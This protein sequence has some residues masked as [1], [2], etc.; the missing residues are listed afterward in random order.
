MSQFES[1][2]TEWKESW[3]DDLL[4]WVSGFANAEGGRLEIGRNDKGEIVGLADASK[5]LED[6]PNKI[7]DL[8]GILVAV[9][10]HH[11]KGKPWIAIEVDAYPNPI[12]YRGHYYI[13]SGSTLQELKGAALD[14]FLLRKQGRTWDSVPVPKVKA[15]DLSGAAIKQFRKLAER[16]GR[17]DPADLRVSDTA[18]IDKLKLT[19]GTYLKRAALLLFHS[20]PEHFVTG[21]FVKIGYFHTA[22]EFAYH[23]EV[24][25]NLF[26]QSAKTIDLVRTK[27]LKAAIT[28]EGIHRIERYPVPD[29]ALREAILNALVHRDYA[30]GAPVQIRAYED[31]LRIWNPAVLPEGWTS[32]SLLADH[33][34]TPFNPDIANAFFRAGEIETWGRGIQRIFETCQKAGTP[35]PIIDYKPNDLWI[36]FPFS[37]EY[38]KAIATTSKGETLTGGNQKTSGKTSGK[39]V[40]LMT[41]NALITIPELADAIGITERSIE[42]TIK[43]LQEEG[44]LR[45]IGPAK[46]G[47]WEVVS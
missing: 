13:R 8:L 2:H 46:G 37:A 47:H 29:V 19:E 34:S 41:A 4:R 28:Y 42:R 33:A 39:I 22:A 7:R 31:R 5:L 36:E 1:Q 12:S 20:D 35:T 6:L 26:E 23:D 16:S 25:G 3:R 21:A 32:E 45:R 14:R 40:A 11:T 43:K 10:L 24:H 38:L 9:N 18:L 44:R 30:V 17:L 15:T 27:Y